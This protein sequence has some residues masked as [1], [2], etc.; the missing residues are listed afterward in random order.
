MPRTRSA[1]ISPSY[2]HHSASPIAAVTASRAS[3]ATPAISAAAAT[4]SSTVMFWFFRL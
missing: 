4:L 2:G 1:G 3:C